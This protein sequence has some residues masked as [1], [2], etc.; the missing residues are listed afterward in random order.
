MAKVS[1]GLIMYRLREN[2]IEVL[3]VH[4]GGP[5]WAK[6]DEGAW[7]VPKGEILP[8]EDEMAAALR[9]FREE[10]SIEPHGDF[11]S[12][13]RVKHKSGKWV[14]AWAFQGDCEVGSIV[15]NTFFLE[16]PPRSGNK[17][18]FPEIDRAEFFG[19]EDV[20]RK[21]FPGELELVDRL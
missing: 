3:L 13:G 8:G 10:L 21:I 20:R 15:S 5:F 2:T 7:F 19:P 18:E 14:V 17:Q 11:L 6:K 16:W 9:E 4:P 12:L 1:A